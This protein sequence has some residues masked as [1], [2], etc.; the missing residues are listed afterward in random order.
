MKPLLLFL[1]TVAVAFSEWL[2]FELLRTP[3]R[4]PHD[5]LTFLGAEKY[6]LV[7][8]MT[9]VGIAWAIGVVLIVATTKLT[10]RDLLAFIM[11]VAAILALVQ[12]IVRHPHRPVTPWELLWS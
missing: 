12:Y 5:M 10:I 8:F 3:Y 4:P 1:G 11:L 7:A 9:F 6:G 2:M